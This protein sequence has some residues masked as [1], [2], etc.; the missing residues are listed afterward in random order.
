VEYRSNSGGAITGGRG[1]R[2]MG[3]FF[4]FF[5]FFFAI[6]LIILVARG[7]DEPLEL[8]LFSG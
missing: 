7:L 4:F 8:L 6:G 3:N 5:L 1:V 2:L